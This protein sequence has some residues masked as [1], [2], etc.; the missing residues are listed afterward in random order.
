MIELARSLDRD[1]ARVALLHRRGSGFG[2]LAALGVRAAASD[3]TFVTDVVTYSSLASGLP[4]VMATL[5]QQRPDLVI[6]AGPFDDE[7]LLARAL[8]EFGLRPK[9]VGL[10]P[11]ALGEIGLSNAR[12]PPCSIRR[13]Q[14][15][16]SRSAGSVR[17]SPRRSWERSAT[18]AGSPRRRPS[19]RTP[20]Q[21]RSQPRGARSSGTGCTAAGT[22]S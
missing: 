19:P 16:C 20:A 5:E 17:S 8:V 13:R 2:R 12:S 3:A 18:S 7:V 15:T 4:R 1:V 22:V 9:A 14:R 6:S 21:L 11:L 10:A